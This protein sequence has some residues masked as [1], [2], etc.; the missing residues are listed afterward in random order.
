M[1]KKRV[2]FWLSLIYCT[3]TLQ[4]K[5]IKNWFYISCILLYALIVN[6]CIDKNE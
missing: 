1:A 2:K 4:I 3:V 6:V 5:M